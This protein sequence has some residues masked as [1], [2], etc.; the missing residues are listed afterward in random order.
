MVDADRVGERR[1]WRESWPTPKRP[2]VLC[3]EEL[4]KPLRRRSQMRLERSTCLTD[5]G[6]SW[7]QIAQSKADDVQTQGCWDVDGIE[8]HMQAEK[9]GRLDFS[10]MFTFQGQH[11]G[12]GFVNMLMYLVCW[13]PQSGQNQVLYHTI[14]L[15]NR[16]RITHCFCS[17]LRSWYHLHRPSPHP[18]HSPRPHPHHRPPR[19]WT[20]AWPQQCDEQVWQQA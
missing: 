5:R 10:F 11:R 4:H 18:K 17:S 8:V 1:R 6:I 13:T 12:R 14:R 7:L 20:W 15:R 19:T 2:G 9:S 3:H 16:S